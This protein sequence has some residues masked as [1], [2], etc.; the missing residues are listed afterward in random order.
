MMPIYTIGH[1]TRTLERELPKAEIKEWRKNMKLSLHTPNRT[2]WIV[3]L[4]LFVVGFFFSIGFVISAA[5][6]LLGTTVI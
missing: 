6:L 1:S 4:I 3:A 5:L 2:L